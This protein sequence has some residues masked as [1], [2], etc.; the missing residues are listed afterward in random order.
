MQTRINGTLT[1]RNGRR[2]I[3]GIIITE[4]AVL[5]NRAELYTYSTLSEGVIEGNGTLW[6]HVTSKP[7][8]GGIDAL[9]VIIYYPVEV[10]FV[11]PVPSGFIL[12]LL[13]GQDFN[14]TIT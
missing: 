14:G 7:I 3:D 8:G 9:Q 13:D 1:L 4:N 11:F 6:A 5:D 2:T 10:G 12:S